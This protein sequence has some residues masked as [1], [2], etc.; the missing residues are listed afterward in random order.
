[1]GTRHGVRLA[2]FQPACPS[3]AENAWKDI[4]PS[5]MVKAQA[6]HNFLPR[7]FDKYKN[8]IMKADSVISL[9]GDFVSANSVSL[10]KIFV[11]KLFSASCRVVWLL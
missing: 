9:I 3:T 1:M 8:A 10:S 11:I 6:I 7:S 2:S 5:C 4:D